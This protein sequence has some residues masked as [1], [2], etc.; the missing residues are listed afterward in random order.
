V[1]PRGLNLYYSISTVCRRP[2][3]TPFCLSPPTTSVIIPVPAP[4]SHARRHR[5]GTPASPR[6]GQPRDLQP[7]PSLKIEQIRHS[8]PS[9]RHTLTLAPQPR[10]A[11]PSAS[12]HPPLPPPHIQHADP[13]PSPRCLPTAHTAPTPR[14]IPTPPPSS[15]HPRR[16][17]H[18]NPCGRLLRQEDDVVR[19]GGRAEARE[20]NKDLVGEGAHGGEHHGCRL[21]RSCHHSSNPHPNTYGQ[22][23]RAA[24]APMPSSDRTL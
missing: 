10:A 2:H 20:P 17:R 15:S 19:G 5:P 4:R 7:P 6:L 11:I 1:H 8:A 22:E 16:P 13:A 21:L 14:V 18:P 23:S 24:M 9:R 12:P 3:R